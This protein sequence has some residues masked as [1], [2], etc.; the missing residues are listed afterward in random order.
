MTIKA[1]IAAIKK[2]IGVE[3]VS[4][5]CDCPGLPAP[6]VF[7]PESPGGIEEFDPAVDVPPPFCQLCGRCHWPLKSISF[8][9]VPPVREPAPSVPLDPPAAAPPAP[10]VP[11]TPTPSTAAIQKSEAETK[12]IEAT[13]VRRVWPW[14]RKQ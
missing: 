5:D 10:S 2:A 9:T 6:L 12:T 7:L 14:E 3:L 4:P 13:P 11:P 8:V 1:D